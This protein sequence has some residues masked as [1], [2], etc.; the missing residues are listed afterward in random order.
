MDDERI[1]TESN[2]T[3]RDILVAI[4]K[5]S[6]DKPLTVERLAD[7]IHEEYDFPKS[8]CMTLAYDLKEYEETRETD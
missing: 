4:E 7:C 8:Y 1:V 5:H 6:G 3:R 2:I